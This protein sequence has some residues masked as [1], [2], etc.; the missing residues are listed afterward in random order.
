[1]RSPHAP[2]VVICDDVGGGPV[3]LRL[4]ELVALLRRELS[5]AALLVLPEICETPEVLVD[6]LAA[7]E[8]RRVVV[9]CRRASQRR[10]ELLAGLRRAGAAAACIDVIDLQPTVGCTEQVA[11]E[12]SV[13]LVSA[14]LARVVHT[15]IEAPVKERTSLSV[16]GVSRR[17][18]LRGPNKARR[19]I[20]VWRSE[21]CTG[22]TAGVAWTACVLA[23]PHGAL[24]REAGRVVVD[25]DRC[26]GCGAC[27]SACSRGA[28][29]F[30]G[31]EVEG[32][33]A[34]AA[35]L[36]AAIRRGGFATG[37]AIAC[38]HSNSVPSV[39]ELCL[40]L[41]VP[42][43]EMV[44][45]GWLLQLVGAAVG[46]L[47]V[48]CEDEDCKQRADDLGHFLDDFARALE[49]SNGVA[50]SESTRRPGSDGTVRG[51]M[52]GPDELLGQR[53]VPAM[54]ALG[55][56]QI[57]L[58]EPQATMQ[59]LGALAALDPNRT[60]WRVEGAG[61]SLGVVS[62]EPGS[63]SLC[64]VCVGVCHTGA[65][66]AE[67]DMNGSLRLSVDFGLCTACGAC[68][69]SCPEAAITL[70]RA[71]DG[72]LVT[73]GRRAVATL[74][75]VA[76]EIC[77]APLAGRASPAVLRRRPGDSHPVLTTGT[78]STCADCRLG[79]HS[80]KATHPRG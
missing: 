56:T 20:A 24:R 16:G 13:A 80:V 31:A 62:I 63:C 5:G 47:V 67:P 38:Q 17:S 60:G 32:L 7:T 43:L 41:R 2:V 79:G 75:A 11:L 71:V 42:S 44:T 8:P 3:P 1:M 66:R 72:A 50:A 40:A 64:E 34:A 59:A 49:Y 9:G 6:A 21:R 74:P 53:S 22:C 12:Q 33:G 78:N 30:P 70:E 48:A 4:G 69:A 14:G 39:G 68:G 45:A 61:C 76:C 55:Q 51:V 28:F 18:F 58:R 29:A 52:S 57:E 19:F 36:V 27:V 10:G 15:D 46:V 65:L 26:N 35:V 54:S 37:V 73:A 23:C 77:G 25:G